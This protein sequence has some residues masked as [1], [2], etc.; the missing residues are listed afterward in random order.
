MSVGARKAVSCRSVR[1]KQRQNILRSRTS[2][3]LFGS[4]GKEIFS[5]SF[6]DVPAV[7]LYKCCFTP[8]PLSLFLDLSFSQTA[9]TQWTGNVT[10]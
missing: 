4:A 5:V 1:D 2:N 10:A 9:L 8:D 6:R 3:V 7:S